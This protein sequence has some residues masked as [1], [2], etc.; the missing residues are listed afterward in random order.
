[1]GRRAVVCAP[2]G[3]LGQVRRH[4]HDHHH[5]LQTTVRL[6]APALQGDKVT[7]VMSVQEGC[8]GARSSTLRLFNASR[9]SVPESQLSPNRHAW[10]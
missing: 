10:P 6:Q 7:T 4:V 2:E 8:E 5:V 9:R 1:M 3:E